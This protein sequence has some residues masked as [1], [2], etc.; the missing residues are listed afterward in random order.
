M[1]GIFFHSTIYSKNAHSIFVKIENMQ[2][3]SQFK[4][5]STMNNTTVSNY[6]IQCIELF[7]E[8]NHIS[9]KQCSDFTLCCWIPLKIVIQYF[10]VSHFSKIYKLQLLDACPSSSPQTILC[11]SFKIVVIRLDLNHFI[12]K[13]SSVN[14][15]SQ[16]GHS[17]N[18]HNLQLYYGMLRSPWDL[19][20]V[21]W[22]LKQ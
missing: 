11:L 17:Q 21:H 5:N 18:R 6:S 22:T 2:N 20:C 1:T 3:Q 14:L 4:F 9:P 12:H 16:H 10:D 13:M 7:W 15:H 8:K 19:K